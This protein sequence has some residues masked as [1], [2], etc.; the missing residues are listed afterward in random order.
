MKMAQFARF[1]NNATNQVLGVTGLQLEN[2]QSMFSYPDAINVT[3]PKLVSGK[4]IYI[5]DGAPLYA[6]RASV[7][8]EPFQAGSGDPSP[9]NV[10]AISGWNGVKIKVCGNNIFNPNKIPDNARQ[11][12]TV[13]GNKFV[14]TV[15]SNGNYKS[16]NF[17]IE[18][19]FE[20]STL[21]L[22]GAVQNSGNNDGRISVR[23]LHGDTE[24]DASNRLEISAQTG[25][26]IK[27]VPQGTTKL[28]VVCYSSFLNNATTGDKSTFTDVVLSLNNELYS[29]FVSHDYNITFSNEAGTV[30]GGTLDIINGLLTVNRKWIDL[31][32]LLYI[33]HPDNYFQ[34]SHLETSLDNAKR[35]SSNINADIICSQYKT[36]P[37]VTIPN[38]DNVIGIFWYESENRNIL[39]IKD[40]RYIDSSVNE[41]KNAMNGVTLVY[42]LNTPIIYQIQPTNILMLNSINTIFANCG[43]MELEYYRRESGVN[44]YV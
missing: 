21:H 8:I 32:T 22:S 18:G 39:R 5:E 24:I 11:T 27:Q 40:N 6:K 35:Y 41:F 10:R 28:F 31:G 29:P 42:P 7:F 43:S 25:F 2:L 23:F 13:N 33:K 30:Y 9:S 19:I 15:L 20:G 34:T 4:V 36:N 38:F 1:A 12:C 3:N 14:L 26:S 44:P 17:E 37:V 16:S